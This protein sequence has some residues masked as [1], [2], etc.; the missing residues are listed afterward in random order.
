M[1]MSLSEFIV[2]SCSELSVL[3]CNRMETLYMQFFW[4]IGQEDMMLDTKFGR[5]FNEC[6]V[7]GATLEKLCLPE[8]ELKMF[9][10]GLPSLN[11]YVHFLSTGSVAELTIEPAV[12]TCNDIDLMVYTPTSICLCGKE[13]VSTIFNRQKYNDAYPENIFCFKILPDVRYPGFVQIQLQN[14]MTYCWE[15]G[16]YISKSINHLKIRLPHPPSFPF[17]ETLKHGPAMNFKH[18]RMLSNLSYEANEDFD[19]EQIASDFVRCLK[20]IDWP[21]EASEWITRT[22]LNGWPSPEIISRIVAEGCHVVPV[23]HPD[24]PN[25]IYQWRLSFSRAETILMN[26]VT[27]VQQVTY[28]LLRFIA[29]KELIDY[30]GGSMKTLNNYHLKTLIFWACERKPVQWWE[31]GGVVVVCCRLFRTLLS[32]LKEKSCP[33]YFIKNCNLLSFTH[34]KKLVK[35]ISAKLQIL[36]EPRELSVWLKEKY[37][38]LAIQIAIRKAK[39][40]EAGREHLN[41]LFACLECSEYVPER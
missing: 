5:N 39:F 15:T 19:S 24:C 25:D 34:D 27:H 2:A 41:D 12:P 10:S 30:E 8:K 29:K 1:A 6:S 23:S 18:K 38:N 26:S 3:N 36:S 7:R 28:H 22:R 32:W 11:C 14:R 35:A 20:C 33:N 37:V 16:E 17:V 13:S 40:Y 9:C 4:S 31:S 21:L